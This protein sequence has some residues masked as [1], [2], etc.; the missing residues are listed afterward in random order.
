M[1]N[2]KLRIY[3]KI[4]HR[5]AGKTFAWLKWTKVFFY[6]KI[7]IWVWVY[8][9]FYQY[10]KYSLYYWFIIFFFI[11]LLT[12]SVIYICLRIGWINKN[13]HFFDWNVKILKIIL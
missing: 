8:V 3:K 6:T 13:Y 9:P 12:D 11:Y 2:F 1:R 5:N 7:E 4:D 10:N